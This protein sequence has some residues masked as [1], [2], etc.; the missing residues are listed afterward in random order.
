MQEIIYQCS[1]VSY[2]NCSLMSSIQQ[3]ITWAHFLQIL[4][5][6]Y[7]THYHLYFAILYISHTLSLVHV[8]LTYFIFDIQGIKNT[9]GN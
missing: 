5:Y 1:F 7:N 3:F 2:L 9:F 6:N 8:L 4:I